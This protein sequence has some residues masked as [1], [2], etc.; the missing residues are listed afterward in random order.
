ML[1][2]DFSKLNHY[3]S[4]PKNETLIEKSIDNEIID[5]R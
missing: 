3:F 5:C 1:S 4:N 2:I